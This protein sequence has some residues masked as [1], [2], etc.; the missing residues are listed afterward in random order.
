LL[1]ALMTVKWKSA[2]LLVFLMAC[3][4]KV[5]HAQ[6]AE[7]GA[8]AGNVSDPSGAVVTGATV[9][10]T[11]ESTGQVRNAV[12]RSDGRY[13]V[14]LLPP[15]V[16]KVTV[17]KTGF[18]EEIENGIHIDVGGTARLD[19]VMALGESTQQITVEASPTMTDTESSTL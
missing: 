5:S 8:L 13:T 6:S 16:Y 18:R 19:I 17:K 1:E 12:S 7:T 10:A 11:N 2:W 3:C 14:A 15:G 4:P 9:E